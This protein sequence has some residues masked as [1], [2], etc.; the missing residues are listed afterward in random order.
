MPHH[1]PV[2]V[3]ATLAALASAAVAAVRFSGRSRDRRR[4]TPVAA[5]AAE[6]A[7]ASAHTGPKREA[8]AWLY[9]AEGAR[10]LRRQSE[11]GEAGSY[12]GQQEEAAAAAA[13]ALRRL[14]SALRLCPGPTPSLVHAAALWHQ[15][16]AFENL[17]RLK[18]ALH[19]ATLAAR[20]RVATAQCPTAAW[21][22]AEQ[23][24]SGGRAG[25]RGSDGDDG[26]GPSPAT[27]VPSAKVVA[28]RRRQL[29]QAMSDAM[30][31][32]S[33]DDDDDADVD[34]RRPP[35]FFVHASPLFYRMSLEAVSDVPREVV[36]TPATGGA[37]RPT[38]IRARLRL[39]SEY[40][41]FRRSDLAVFLPLHLGARLLQPQRGVSVRVAPPSPHPAD[42]PAGCIGGTGRG[43][44]DIQ[45]GW[46]AGSECGPP[47][48]LEIEIFALGEQDGQLPQLA[49]LL[50]STDTAAPRHRCAQVRR[51]PVS[52]RW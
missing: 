36:Y 28:T 14:A 7:A 47:T 30:S 16:V 3:L 5:T 1:Q 8:A 10:L 49:Q 27:L 51:R 50:V 52:Y 25:G 29:A 42:A 17:G 19:L 41:R 6:M 22:A 18:L 9:C 12:E 39:M 45:L 24:G 38:I 43:V 40:G 31:S 35:P 34:S 32:G 37:S 2:V 26:A 23:R 4:Q 21:F 15:S 20:E 13:A 11:G 44:V 46:E 33:S 48:T